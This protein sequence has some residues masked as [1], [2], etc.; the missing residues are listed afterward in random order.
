[1]RKLIIAVLAVGIGL[2]AFAQR[3]GVQRTNIK[4]HPRVNQ[5]NKRINNQ[6][7]RIIEERKEGDLTH[8]EA[9]EVRKDLAAINKE[10]RQMRKAHNGHL[11]KK[12]QVILNKQLNE[13]SKKIGN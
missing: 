11:T 8:K 3:P 5:V 6:E 2:S 10:K 4:N 13:T 12:D 9:R 1:M 7:Q